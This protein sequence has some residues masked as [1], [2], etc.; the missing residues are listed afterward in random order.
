MQ[1]DESEQRRLRELATK[2]TGHPIERG[3]RI[4]HPEMFRDEI[5]RMW[6]NGSLP[7]QRQEAER[8]FGDSCR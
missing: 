3:R 1:P 2:W 6:A 5:S 7:L 4:R 8:L